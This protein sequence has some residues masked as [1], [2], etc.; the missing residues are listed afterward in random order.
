LRQRIFHQ[1]LLAKSTLQ[2][3][4]GV[5]EVMSIM[6]MDLSR[7]L[8][9]LFIV[10]LYPN[11]AVRF[12]IYLAGLFLLSWPMTLLSLGAFGIGALLVRGHLEQIREGGAAFSVTNRQLNF[13]VFERLMHAR[14][15]RLSGTEKAEARAVFD[16]SRQNSEALRQQNLR[17]ARLTLLPEPVAVGFAYVVLFVGGHLLGFSLEVLGMFVLILI[18]LLPIV[19]GAVSKY[20]TVIGQVASLEK[21]DSYVRET[22]EAREPKGGN[23]RF[24]NLEKAI[25]YDH[26]SFTYS[27]A[28]APALRD[29]TVDIPA[30]RMT[31]L[32]GPSGAGKSTF[33]D[34]LPRLRLPSSGEILIDDIAISEFSVASVRAGIA[35][36]SQVPQIFN[37]TI[38]EHIRYGKGDATD[39]EIREA[40]RLAGA[41]P[42]IEGLPAGFKTH[43]G[44]GG[45][46]LSGGQRQRLDIARALVRRAPILVL[47]EPTSALDADAE[48]AFRDALKTLRSETNLTIIV[49]A[50]RLS[51]IVDADQIIV[52]NNGRVDAV[53]THDELVAARGW[54]AGALRKQQVGAVELAEGESWQEIA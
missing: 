52:L 19:R 10:I 7:G 27:A 17:T 42:F 39:E 1:Y 18:R 3:N 11:T 21:L 13:F 24:S 25:R 6:K 33:V 46:R 4:S 12:L 2:D 36:V 22:Q 30:H 47:D 32:V 14:L 5:A 53:G 48:S 54:Y 50:H 28:A 31:A 45:L 26:L 41:L 43:L 37:A 38:A 20:A 35:F 16:V 9:T 8:N 23:R 29:V 49:I 15:I 34:L 40:A 44:E 51:T